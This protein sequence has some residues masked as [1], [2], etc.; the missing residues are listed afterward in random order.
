MQ[1]KLLRSAL[2]LLALL[3]GVFE[4]TPLWAGGNNWLHSVLRVDTSAV[5]DAKR[6]TMQI[7]ATAIP[8]RGLPDTF[9]TAWLAVWPEG[10]PNAPQGFSQVGLITR[11]DGLHWFVYS[12]KGITCRRGQPHWGTLGCLGDVNDIVGLNQ[13]HRVELVKNTSEN[14]WR[15]RVYNTSNTYFDVAEIPSTS[16][17]IYRA[18]ADF[19]E[20]YIEPVDPLITGNFYLYHP[21]YY[22]GSTATAWPFSANATNQHNHIELQRKV[23]DTFVE[24]EF[25]CPSKYGITPNIVYGDIWYWYAGTGGAQCAHLFPPI[26][27][28]NTNAALTYN[29]SSWV[30]SHSPQIPGCCPRAWKNTLSWATTV[31]DNVRLHNVF[32]NNSFTRL[33]T[34]S[35]TRGATVVDVNGTLSYYNDYAST[36]RWQVAKTWSFSPGQISMAVADNGGTSPTIYTD[37]DAYIIDIPR[38]ANATYDNYHYMLQYIGSWTHNSTGVPSASN[39]TLSWSN[40]AQDAITFTFEGS[41]ITYYYTKHWNRGKAGITIDDIDK[42]VIDACSA[43]TQ[44]QQ[45]ALFSGLGAG[46]HTIHI[47]NLGQSSCGAGSSYMY[48]DVDKLV[49]AP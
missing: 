35:P 16:N 41:K 27:Y 37:L 40:N 42:G 26:V 39:K 17:R 11:P 25:I 7:Q 8:T 38:V 48:I 23:N 20:G 1:H 22:S 18:D 15:A 30:H 43:T 9:T 47:S 5:Y 6:Y 29:G 19:E 12:L 2:F 46:V 10:S 4:S 14:F 31:P 36:N 21:E 49:P 32:V 34:K 28:D 45:S 13:F 24:P 33:Y 44:W 3:V